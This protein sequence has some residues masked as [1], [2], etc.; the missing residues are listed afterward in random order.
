MFEV[1]FENEIHKQ[2]SCDYIFY[3]FEDAKEYLKD[4]GFIQRDR[5]FI[6]ENYN[7]ITFQKAYISPVK[8]YEK[9]LLKG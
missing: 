7:W 1:T 9:V 3:E 6:R 5:V 2:W 8:V 4:I